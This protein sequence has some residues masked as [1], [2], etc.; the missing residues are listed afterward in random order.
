MQILLRAG[1]LGLLIPTIR[2]QWPTVKE[3]IK[4]PAAQDPDISAFRAD[5]DELVSLF[6]K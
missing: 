2:A 3:K 5:I 6:K 1:Q 4:A